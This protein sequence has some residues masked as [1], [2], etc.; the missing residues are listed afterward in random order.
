MREDRAKRLTRRKPIFSLVLIP[1][2]PNLQTRI[3]QLLGV[4]TIRQYEKYLGLPALV[5]G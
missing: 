4:P 2:P 1:P 5:E 3:Q